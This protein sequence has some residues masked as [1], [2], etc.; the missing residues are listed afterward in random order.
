MSAA[1]PASRARAFICSGCSPRAAR[2]FRTSRSCR[3]ASP[4]KRPTRR[5]FELD[6][7]SRRL[8]TVNEIDRFEG[9]PGGAV[10]AYAIDPSGKLTLLNQRASLGANPCQLALEPKGRYLLV[11]NCASGSVAVLPIA[12]DGTIGEATD[13]SSTAGGGAPCIALDPSGALSWCA[14]VPLVKVVTLPI[15]CQHGQGD[16]RHGKHEYPAA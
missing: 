15:R 2:S 3:S 13:R 4:R 7:Q 1:T 10:S 5:Y 6:L 11:A 9:K 8:F 12:A 14:T 16:V